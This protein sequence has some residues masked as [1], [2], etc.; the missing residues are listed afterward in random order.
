MLLLGVFTIIT[1]HGTVGLWLGL[2]IDPQN[3]M[4]LSRLQLIFWT[5]VVLSGFLAAALGNIAAGAPS[6]LAIA[7]PP[8]LWLVMGISTT[9][10]VSSQLIRNRK[11]SL[12]IAGPAKTAV[13]EQFAQHQTR[14]IALLESQGVDPSI[15]EEQ[16]QT[17]GWKWPEDARLPDLFQEGGR[18]MQGIATWVRY[19]CSISRASLCWPTRYRLAP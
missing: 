5:L 6:P 13:A 17:I 1:G 3:R 10:L 15:V 11:M 7:S 12:P 8:Q 4:S 14:E 16:G 9:S 19:R 2:L 18:A